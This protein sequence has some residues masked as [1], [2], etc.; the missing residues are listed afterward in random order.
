MALA[1]LITALLSFVL[2]RP[3]VAVCITLVGVGL[4]T[5]V[6]WR[7][8]FALRS[9]GPASLRV[10]VDTGHEDYRALFEQVPLG[11]VTFDVAGKLRDCNDYFCQLVSLPREQLAGAPAA[12]MRDPGFAAAIAAALTGEPCRHEGPLSILGSIDKWVSLRAEPH[13][14]GHGDGSRDGCIAIVTDM[15]EGKNN[16]QLIERLAFTDSLTGLANRTLL[17]DRMRQ[18]IAAAERNRSQVA[19]VSV[20]LD[21]FKIINDSLGSAVGDLLLQAVAKRLTKLLRRGDTLCRSGGDQFILLTPD[22]KR[23]ADTIAIAEKIGESFKKLWIIGDHEFHITASIGVAIYPADGTDEGTLIEQ[24]QT[25]MRRAKKEGGDCCHFYALSMN[26]RAAERFAMETALRRALD[27]DHAEDLEH[28]GAK[29]QLLVYYQPQIDLET[30][31][32]VGIE[33]LVRWQH[34]D[35]GLIPPMRFIPL[36][37]ETALIARIDC[38]VLHHACR[39]ARAWQ[40]LLGRPLRLAVNL[41]ARQFER[42][43]LLKVVESALAESGLSPHQLEL[44]ITETVAMAGSEHTTHILGQLP[45]MGVSIAL[46]DFGTGF[47]SLVHLCQLPINRLKVDRSFV[48]NLE[49]DTGAAAIVDGVLGMGKTL[50]VDVLAE[51]VETREQANY[52]SNAGCHEVQGFLYSRPLSSEDCE[53]ML[54]SH[55]ILG[56]AVN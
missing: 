8:G 13:V 39:Q 44:E 7:A 54:L 23:T 26:E 4:L 14:N 24:A 21:R 55:D 53:K 1:L 37:E 41:S 9:A 10:D 15:T 25:A 30:S 40:D 12:D 28:A 52:L 45:N 5:V 33:A 29:H 27:A 20:N 18:A 42:A 56:V 47:S 22:V 31:A 38:Y 43:D 50:G 3:W 2:P 49:K 16:E 32:V 17:R 6:I 19:V 36:A 11:V 46:D 48:M 35:L 34:P 51:G